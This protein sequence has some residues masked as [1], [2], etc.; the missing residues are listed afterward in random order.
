MVNGKIVGEVLDY[1][2]QVNAAVN[3]Q[4]KDD[5]LSQKGFSLCEELKNVVPKDD[6]DKEILNQLMAMCECGAELTKENA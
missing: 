6:A 3:E 2:N 5:S 1:I 4:S